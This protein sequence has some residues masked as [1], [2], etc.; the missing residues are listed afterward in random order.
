M[1]I[2][3]M[4]GVSA[5]LEYVGPRGKKRKKNCIYNKDNICHHLK[6][7][8][9]LL[10]CVGRTYCSYFDDLKTEEN[11]NSDDYETNIIF[12]KRYK[13]ENDKI[14]KN[15]NLNLRENLL[16]RKVRLLDIDTHEIIDITIVEDKDQDLSVDKVSIQSPLGKALSK[17]SIGNKFEVKQRNSTV[18][19][20]LMNIFEIG[21]K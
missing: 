15:E 8:S 13:R 20:L 10:H 11:M 17:T 18:K 1:G 6:S 3:Q 2:R 21:K 4:Q 14:N 16:Y 7:P 5:Y 9:Y 19:Y 12:Q